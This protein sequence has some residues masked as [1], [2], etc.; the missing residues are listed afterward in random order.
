MATINSI[1]DLERVSAQLQE[2]Q[3]TLRSSQ[4]LAARLVAEKTKIANDA[5]REAQRIATLAGIDFYFS[6]GTSGVGI[7]FDGENDRWQTS[8]MYC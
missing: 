7:T 2:L 6:L 5:I 8:S 4:E 1:D 3:E